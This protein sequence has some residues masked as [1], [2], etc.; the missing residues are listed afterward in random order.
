MIR[1]GL[2]QGSI[3]EMEDGGL[4]TKVQIVLDMGNKWNVKVL[5]HHTASENGTFRAVNKKDLKVQRVLI[6]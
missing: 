3:L 2:R 1:A 4:I 6:Y 5:E